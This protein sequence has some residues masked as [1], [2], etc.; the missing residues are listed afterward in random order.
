[1]KP[2]FH[3]DSSLP[4]VERATA[5]D[6]PALDELF[7]RHLPGLRAWVV[8]RAGDIVLDRESASDIVQSACRE[9][10]E[11]MDRFRWG[12]EA[13]FRH[14]LYETT[15]RKIRRRYAHWHAERRDVA[16]L[17]ELESQ[18]LIEAYRTIATP[19]ADVDAYEALASV[20]RAYRALPD[21]QQEVVAMS[22]IAGL[23]NAEIAER[24]GADE[25]TVRTRLHRGLAAIAEALVRRKDE[26]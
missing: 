26:A 10:L 1:M 20:E 22:R 11:H 17:R 18:E 4:L 13:G 14:W 8:L 2:P 21:E 7:A 5:G 23:T 15:L 19:S 3:D 12:G 24:T 25:S 6:K 9:V 16:K